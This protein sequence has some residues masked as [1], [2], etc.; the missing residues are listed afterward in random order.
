MHNVV[1]FDPLFVFVQNDNHV[2]HSKL[3]VKDFV[4]AHIVSTIEMKAWTCF[5]VLQCNGGKWR[6]MASGVFSSLNKAMYL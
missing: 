3:N 5:H 4:L 1:H 6:V 2:L